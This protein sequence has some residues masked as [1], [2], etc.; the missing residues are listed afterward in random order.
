M[1]RAG[2]LCCGALF[3]FA[4][5]TAA[6]PGEETPP[7]RWPQFRGPN[8]SGVATG[9]APVEFGPERNVRWKTA[10]PAGVSSPCIW[11]G[12]IFL[13]GYDTQ[14]RQLQVL[15]LSRADGNILWRAPVAAETIEKVH[16]LN[17]PASGTPATDGE[18]VY[19]YFGSVGLVAFDFNGQ[20]LWKCELPTP[21]TFFGSGTSPVVAE[22]LV[23]LNRDCRGDSFL[24]AVQRTTGEEVWRRTHAQSVSMQPEGYATPVVAGDQ[25]I[26]HR[27]D[28][29]YAY[30]VAD[31]SQA[32]VART[33]SEASSTPVVTEDAVYVNA[34]TNSGEPELRVAAP[35]WAELVKKHDQDGDGALNKEEFPDDL[36]LTRRAE[37][38]DTRDG[39]V[40]YEMFFDRMDQN[41]DGRVSTL[42]WAGV[43]L[44]MSLMMSADHGVLAIRRGGSGDVS[45][46]HVAWKESRQVPE[47][48]SPLL[49]RDRLYLIKDG[50]VLTCLDPASGAVKFRGR[51][52]AGGGYYASPIAADGRIYL[53]S[54][55]GMLTVVAAGDEMNVLARSDF[56]EPLIATPG[57]ADGTL[58]VRT[59]TALYAIHD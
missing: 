45:R 18:R 46:T 48:P 9:A 43:Q 55:E 7:A 30:S 32:W 3:V 15:C 39:E 29:V 34:W 8:G 35:N 10:V 24:L 31:G 20:Q 17:S 16:R 2:S 12:R 5:L 36:A 41:K 50:G 54:Q 22:E 57:I 6:A 33:T 58:Y 23:L 4:V 51:V 59:G 47:V 37:L 19:A 40:R 14:A 13:T 42:E 11:D 38:G 26:M 21:G 27:N 52:G 53:A 28:G 56:G 44:M 49:Y 1:L 25:V